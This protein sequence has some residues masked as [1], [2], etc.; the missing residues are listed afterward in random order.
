VIVYNFLLIFTILQYIMLKNTNLDWII[1]PDLIM[2]ISI[3]MLPNILIVIFKLIKL[4]NS[5]T[6]KILLAI[7]FS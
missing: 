3:S 4:N 2:I 6:V 1:L 7:I 5:G